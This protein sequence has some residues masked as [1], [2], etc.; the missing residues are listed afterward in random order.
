MAGKETSKEILAEVRRDRLNKHLN[1]VEAVI[2]EWITDLDAPHPFYWW[3]SEESRKLTPPSPTYP[4]VM[5]MEPLR[6]EPW[7]LWACRS[8][9]V[10]RAEQD[11]ASNHILR[12]HLRKRALWKY[13]TEWRQRLDRI[14]E[15]GVSI[16]EKA[17]EMGNLRAK[18]RKPTEDYKAIALL[19]ALELALGHDP[20]KSYSQAQRQGVCYAGILIEKSAT[21]QQT[22][23]VAEEHW[24]IISELGQSKEMRE[25]ALEWQQ[26]LDLQERMKELAQKAIKSSDI[27]Y[28]CQFCRRL[29]Q[30]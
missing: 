8:V 4:T 22:N 15:L 21:P 28:P 30:E 20:E 16:C 10:P 5:P 2:Q 14:K 17:T 18:G 19:M 24:Q 3:P 13:N 27:L 23:E 7:R 25:L 9:Y 11:T 26:V 12:K 6:L 29:W 1:E